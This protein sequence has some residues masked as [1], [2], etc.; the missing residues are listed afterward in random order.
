MQAC[1]FPFQA[2]FPKDYAAHS[3]SQCHGVHYLDLLTSKARRPREASPSGTVAVMSSTGQTRGVTHERACCMLAYRRVGLHASRCRLCCWCAATARTRRTSNGCG[4]THASCCA[5]AMRASRTMTRRP[6]ALVS[7]SSASPRPPASAPRLPYTQ[8]PHCNQ[9][10]LLLTPLI[11]LGRFG[12]P[13]TCPHMPD[14]RRSCFS[15][16]MLWKIMIICIIF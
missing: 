14:K 11:V 16:N 1:L 10:V 6:S 7:P 2:S 5:A 3:N 4:R 9:P 12:Q 8:G 13:T 15:S